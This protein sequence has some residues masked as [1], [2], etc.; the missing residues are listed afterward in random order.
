MGYIQPQGAGDSSRTLSNLN[1][2]F[3]ESEGTRTNLEKWKHLTLFFSVQQIV[4]VLHGD[5]RGEVVGDGVTYRRRQST[6]F[7]SPAR[8]LLCIA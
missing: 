7:D 5:E 6:G 4:V 8:Y 1:Q 3:I 2:A